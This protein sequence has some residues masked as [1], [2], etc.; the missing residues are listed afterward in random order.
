MS[1]TAKKAKTAKTA[2]V[3]VQHKEIQKPSVQ[4]SSQSYSFDPIATANAVRVRMNYEEQRLDE[5]K[6][7]KE[8]SGKKYLL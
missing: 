6:G 1:R 8:T 5:E 3:H 7:G 2:Y 4:V